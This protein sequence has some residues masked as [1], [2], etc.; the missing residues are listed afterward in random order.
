MSAIVFYSINF[1]NIESV[2]ELTSGSKT[3]LRTQRQAVVMDGER[4]DFACVG[5]T[6]VC[7]WSKPV[8]C[9]F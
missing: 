2:A 8:L 9:M 4:S 3:S 7:P 1:I 5:S 6:G